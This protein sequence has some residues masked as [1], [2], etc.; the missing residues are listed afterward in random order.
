M[1]A[2]GPDADQR[3]ATFNNQEQAR[4]R[5]LDSRLRLLAKTRKAPQAPN[6]HGSRVFVDA[7]AEAVLNRWQAQWQLK[8]RQAR[9]RLVQDRAT[10]Q[11][12]VTLN[13]TAPGD[14]VRC[15]AAMTGAVLCT[16][17][18]LV[19]PPGVALQLKRAMS[20]PRHIFLSVACCDCHRPMVDLIRR[21]CQSTD[22]KQPC[23]WAFYL[24]ADGE[25]RKALFLARARKRGPKHS[26][27]MVTLLARGQI[28]SGAFQAFPNCMTLM[29]FL[30][31]MHQVDASF[32][33]LGFCKR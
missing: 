23:R 22:P 30:A 10:A 26:H 25:K 12:F 13:P 2:L 31:A 4:Q 27:E 20:L 16:P 11:V 18:L 29:S 33:Q 21:V 3:M 9:L 1:E 5:N 24:E 19:S 7:E 17:E 28:R 6:L 15:V 8:C 14:R 32:T